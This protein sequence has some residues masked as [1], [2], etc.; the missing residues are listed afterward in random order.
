MITKLTVSGIG[1]LLKIRPKL[2]TNALGE[3]GTCMFVWECI[4]TEG[5][6]LGT[7][8][9]G[10]LFGSCCG[11]NETINNLD[12]MTSSLATTVDSFVVTV[13]NKHK[14]KWKPTISTISTTSI[15][16]SITTKSPVHLSFTESS[17]KPSTSNSAYFKPFTTTRPW[18]IYTG[19]L[20]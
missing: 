16:T 10:F 3:E 15:A 1:D 20:K 9:D 18:S 14:N 8:V 7:C 4:K 17:L 5:K 19:T 6:H 12:Q 2:C 11:H 13:N